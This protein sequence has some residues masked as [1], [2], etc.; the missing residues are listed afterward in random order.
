MSLLDPQPGDITTS[1]AATV[2]KMVS[3]R[4]CGLLV[5]AGRQNM[6][7]LAH[8]PEGKPLLDLLPVVFDAG[9]ADLVLNELG[10]FQ[11]SEWPV[12]IPPAANGNPV[13][14]LSD[15]ADENAE[16]WNSLGGVF[17]H[18]PVRREKP[19]ATVLL[20]HSNPAMHNAYGQHILLA[21]QFVGSGRTG[22]LAFHR[23]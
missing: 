6:P 14:A 4:G 2:D 13:L 10:H 18:Y 8:N 22:F 3:E 21:T 12:W 19:V 9:K 1:W 17:W 16:V 20:R 11:R 5:V 23:D 15:R 7:R